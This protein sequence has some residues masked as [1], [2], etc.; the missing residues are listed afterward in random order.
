MPAVRWSTLLLTTLLL[1]P[2]LLGILLADTAH[3]GAPDTPATNI[4]L[5]LWSESG[6][7]KLHTWTTGGHGDSE[8]VTIPSG[9]SLFFALHQPLRTDLPVE[10]YNPNPPEI[11]FRAYVYVSTQLF[12]DSHLTLRVR[13]GTSPTG[14]TVIASGDTP[15]SGKL[16]NPDSDNERRVDLYWEDDFGPDYIFD[17]GHYVVLELENDDS[18]D[19]V[20]LGLDTGEGGETPSR[21]IT[22]TNPIR[23]ITVLTEAFNLETSDDDDRQ[24]TDRFEPNLPAELARAF[25]SGTALNAFGAY[26]VASIRV[27]VDDPD[28]EE[29]FDSE[30]APTDRDPDSG[31]VEFDDITW[32]YNDPEQPGAQQ[33]GSGAYTVRVSAVDQQANAYWVE[34]QVEMDEYGVYLWT[35][36][37]QQSVAVGGSVSYQLT[38][39]NSGDS[40]DSFDLQPSDTS[41][42]W[43]VEPQS[44]SSGS[45]APG[46]TETVTFTVSVADSTEMVG[47]YATV[48]IL[49]TSQNSP[50]S[51]K[52]TFDLETKT[53][54]GAEFMV[55]LYFEEG[56]QHVTTTEVD[57]VAGNWNDFALRVANLGQATDSIDLSATSMLL[58]WDVEFEYDGDRDSGITINGLPR[59]GSGDH[60]ANVTVWVRPAEGGDDDT[61]SIQLK[62]T[63]QGNATKTSTATLEVSR[64]FGLSLNVAGGGSTIYANLQPGGTQTVHLSLYS[65]VEGDRDVQ[66]DVVDL[67]SGWSAVYKDG[68]ETVTQ[69]TISEDESMPLDLLVT[70]GNSATY[71][72]GGY[73]VVAVA[74]DLHE[75][76][77]RGRQE[78]T[79]NIALQ[80]DLFQ[81]TASK[82]RAALEPGGSYEFTLELHNP[83]NADDT[84]QLQAPSVPKG[85]QVS[86]PDG[87]SIPVGASRSGDATVRITA[88]DEVRHGDSEKILVTITSSVTAHRVEKT[89]T[90]EVE[91]GFG[92]RLTTTL[93]DLW[94]VFVLLGLVMAVGAA[95]YYRSEEWDDEEWEDED[96]ADDSAHASAA[97]SSG[98]DWDDWD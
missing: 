38:V 40:S 69:V 37:R 85:W 48:S 15:V 60:V 29:L 74:E 56:T 1:A 35:D 98:D 4:D 8:T 16:G 25:F 20:T 9:S 33:T 57:A 80:D 24:A 82:Y 76:T 12:T 52:K 90:L 44:W 61:S 91:Q 62:G 87:N 11:G 22:R 58:D 94:Y 10:S 83:L 47:R 78:L 23:D 81:V 13:D 86:F 18:D 71:Q 93:G 70:A 66:L 19:D 53:V 50:T 97:E 7:G 14:G 2:F 30:L 84:Y 68:G 27:Q 42:N 43:T 21:L 49:A 54:V 75:S 88:S 17:S 39:R 34:L 96:E 41:A 6:E 46:G 95:M 51:Q 59:Q 55:G 65:A 26:D 77:A 79:F 73:P 67:P 64:T 89:L 45:L 72:E 28:G 31:T 36:E 5:F 3:A 92:G 32:N 63:S